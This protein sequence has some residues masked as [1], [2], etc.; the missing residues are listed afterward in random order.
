MSEDNDI[1]RAVSLLKQ[2]L[3]EMNKRNIA[4]TPE[5]YA[6]WYEYVSG[7]NTDLVNEINLL[8]LNK[9]TFT[10][11][12]HRDLYNR[13]IASA[14]ESAVNKLSDGVKAVI[15]D[16]LSKLTS[17]GKGLNAYAQVLNSFS[18]NMETA[19]D[20][21]VIK[22][23]I[24]GLIE[25]THQR[26]N[27]TAAMQSTIENMSAEMKKLRAEVARLN[28]E[29]TT[30]PLTKV[31]NRHSFDLDIEQLMSAAKADNKELTLMV[32][33]IDG[34]G[35]FN[36]KFGKA[37]ADKVLR[38]VATL[39]KKNIKGGDLIARLGSDEFG[40]LLPET[41]YQG[42][43]AVAENVRD[44]L[45]KQ[46]LSDSAAKVQLGTITVS[47]GVSSYRTNEYPEDF[48][49]RAE[50]CLSKARQGGNKVVGEEVLNEARG[51]NSHEL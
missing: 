11:E 1:S 12:V 2:T 35:E 10:S 18:S 44:K 22:D 14:K 33:D 45:A 42:A 37:I 28:S 38:F 51:E 21:N 49:S 24:S 31:N 8:E 41:D 27:A 32:L 20:I 29:T 16:F 19:R 36:E 13:F 23:M 9:T 7:E 6:V 50:R 15:S 25:E 48:I 47:I 30:D 17:E 40:I 46:T 26:E 34:F 5:N 43:L 4:T 39:F 3:P